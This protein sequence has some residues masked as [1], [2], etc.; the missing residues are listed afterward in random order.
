MIKVI[1]LNSSNHLYK[2]AFIL[3]LFKLFLIKLKI[4]QNEN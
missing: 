1:V 4:I 3:D 2:T